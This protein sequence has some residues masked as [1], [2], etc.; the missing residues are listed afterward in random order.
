M[1]LLS[2]CDLPRTSLPV[3]ECTPSGQYRHPLLQKRK[4]NIAML[5]FRFQR[6]IKKKY[7]QFKNCCFR[8]S[9]KYLPTNRK[10]YL[11][12][13]PKSYMINRF[14]S[15]YVM[16]DKVVDQCFKVWNFDKSSEKLNACY[17]ISNHTYSDKG[18]TNS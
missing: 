3:G 12:M 13:E 7:I 11:K 14:F 9:A 6:N 16:F 8:I 17:M 5:S 2:L 10:E 18:F 1:F 4:Y 15:V